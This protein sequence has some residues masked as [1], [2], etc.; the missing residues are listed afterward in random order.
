MP[1]Y[2]IVEEAAKHFFG[3]V[4]KEQVFKDFF[5]RN[6]AAFY[7]APQTIS[8]EQNLEYYTLF[9]QYLKLYEDTLQE[10]IESLHVSVEEFYRELGDVQNDPTV[11]DKK[12]LHFVNYLIACMDY[13]SF[14]KFM[15]R[16]AK[17]EKKAEAKVSGDGGGARLSEGKG[18]GKTYDNDNDDDNRADSKRADREDDFDRGSKSDSK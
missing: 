17:K 18:E 13:D 11:K 4:G 1:K 9:Q 7:D 6:V 5:A 2:V 15:V 8:G 16:A 3:A 12:L 10:Y 14:Y